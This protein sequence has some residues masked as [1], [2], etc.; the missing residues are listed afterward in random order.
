MKALVYSDGDILE[1]KEIP[2]PKPGKGEALIRVEACGICGSEIETFKSHSSRRTPPLVLGHEFCGIVEEVNDGASDLKAGETVVVNSVI[3]CRGCFPCKRGDTHLCANREI[4]GM[5]RPGAIAEFVIAPTDHIYRRPK[6]LA[7]V[8]T[9]L[10]EPMAN[11]VHV[12]NLLQYMDNPT[13]VVIGAG[14]IGLMVLQG[15]IVLKNARVLVSD[16][17]EFRLEEAKKLGAEVVV[18]AQKE[19]VSELCLD[20]AG[21]DGVDLCVDAVGATETKRQSL[22]ILRPGG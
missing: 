9:A 2:V 18:N 21:S 8:K 1:I 19:N 16:I 22:D 14:A 7:P 20:F 6:T 4:F 13:V 12:M 11:A 10:T 5:H 15:A 3:S 17:N